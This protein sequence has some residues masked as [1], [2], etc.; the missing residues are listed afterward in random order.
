MHASLFTISLHTSFS[1]QWTL[2]QILRA[3][4]NSKRYYIE[5]DMYL[6]KEKLEIMKHSFLFCTTL[7][8]LSFSAVVEYSLAF[9]ISLSSSNKIYSDSYAVVIEPKIVKW[10]YH[11]H[12][13]MWRMSFSLFRYLTYLCVIT[14]SFFIFI[15]SIAAVTRR[16]DG[17][18]L[19][20]S[21][22]Q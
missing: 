7:L 10:R 19:P 2:L 4:T 1:I 14:G 21:A 3:L 5:T 11:L 12:P 22:E 20:C 18:R 17:R 8:L 13:L 6:M 15:L 9:H 16:H